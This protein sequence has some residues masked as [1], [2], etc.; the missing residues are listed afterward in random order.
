MK[1]PAGPPITYG[2]A[3][4]YVFGEGG[5]VIALQCI[6]GRKRCRVGMGELPSALLGFG[7]ELHTRQALVVNILCPKVGFEL[8]GNAVHH[9]ICHG[10]FVGMCGL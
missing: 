7:Q 3:R 9:G 10:Q 2:N 6:D 5:A 4:A 8:T 1:A